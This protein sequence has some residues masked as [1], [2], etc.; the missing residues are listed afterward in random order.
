MIYPNFFYEFDSG[1]Q[2]FM[3]A[4][5]K[6]SYTT[7]CDIKEGFRASTGTRQ[8][9][10]SSRMPTETIDCVFTNTN[11]STEL[12]S[13][14]DYI[15]G[16]SV[17][18]GDGSRRLA[19]YVKVVSATEAI[20]PGDDTNKHVTMEIQFLGAVR[21]R[22]RAALDLTA[23]AFVNDEGAAGG[24]ATQI[25]ALWSGAYFGIWKNF[26]LPEGN[27]T[28]FARARDTVHVAKDLILAVRDET[29]GSAVMTYS[30]TVAAGYG[31]Y[32]ADFTLTSAQ[33]GHNLLMQAV[34]GINTPNNIYV[35][36][37]GFVAKP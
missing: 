29:A 3:D 15:K 35:D 21:G 8:S 16:K 27:Y 18:F 10:A 19:S 7:A 12:E 28:I 22:L 30:K 2:F 23:P 26:L 36:M 5:S 11:Y 32:F 17:I 9:L 34:K 14:L 25:T 20:V 37:L 33:N 24:V 1:L 4:V 6:V 31:Y 13:Y